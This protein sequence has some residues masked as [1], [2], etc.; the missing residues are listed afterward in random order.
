MKE[1]VRRIFVVLW[2]IAGLLGLI[3]LIEVTQV[4]NSDGPIYMWMFCCGVLS[5]FQYIMTG[6]PNPVNMFDPPD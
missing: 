5:A 2:V 1:Y 4:K 3:A 6:T